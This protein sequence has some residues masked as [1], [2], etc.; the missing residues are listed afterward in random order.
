[1]IEVVGSFSGRKILVTCGMV[2]L[3]KLQ[4]RQ[5]VEFARLCGIFDF[6]F[7]VS[8]TNRKAFAE[9]L[10]EIGYPKDRAVYFRKLSELQAFLKDFVR[11]GDLVVFE[12][13]LPDNY[14]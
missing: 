1:M 5:N 4:H 10:A 3:G 2:E 13:D 6:L 12:N 7:I 8:R 14:R 11:G 9:G